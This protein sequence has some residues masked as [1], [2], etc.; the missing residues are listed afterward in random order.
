MGE[1]ARG[2]DQEQC[3]P[4]RKRLIVNGIVQGVGF[5]PSVYNLAVKHQLTGFVQNRSGEVIIEIEGLPQMI[6][7]FTQ[8]LY[9][10]NRPASIS[11]IEGIQLTV[12]ADET[13]SILPSETSAHA[14]LIFPPDLKS[15]QACTREVLVD[16][17]SRFY[18]YPFTSCTYCGP[19]YSA[20]RSLPYDRIH[21]TMDPFPMCPQCQRKY[22]SPDDRRF[23][24]QTIACPECGPS[25][26]ICE[27]DGVVVEDWFDFTINQLL[28]GK[29]IAMK[30]I[31][32]FHL[33]CDAMEEQA[34]GRLRQRKQRPRK[35]LALMAANIDT[36]NAFFHVSNEEE[37]ALTAPAAPILLLKPKPCASNKL[38]LHLIAPG[39]HRIGIMLPYTP[40]HAMLTQS[41]DFIVATSGN[42]SGHPIAHTNGEALSQLKGIADFFLLHDREIATRIDDSVGQVFDG[43]FVPIRRSRGIVPEAIA[44]PLPLNEFEWNQPIVF[45]AGAEMKNTFCFLFKGKALFSQHIGDIDNLEQMDAYEEAV[46]HLS[47][48]LDIK[49]D[50]IAYDPHPDYDI[51][52]RI[53]ETSNRR[54]A[55]VYHHHA[56]MTSCMAENM[57]EGPV[58]GCIL[59][60][61]GYG[62][63]GTMWGFEILT[64]DYLDFDRIHHLNPLTLPGGEHGIKN[65]WMVGI[66]LVYEASENERYFNETVKRLF[67]QHADKLPFIRAQLE[68]SIK[69]PKVS[70]AG[71][72]FDGISSI[73]GLCEE[74]AYEGEAAVLLSEVIEAVGIDHHF[75]HTS[76][77]SYPFVS[78]NGKWYISDMIR[79]LI[80]DLEVGIPK[81]EIILKFHHTI[82]EMVLDGVRNA[83]EKSGISEVV[84]SGGVWNNRYLLLYTKKR[85]QQSG[86]IVHTHQKIP[87]GDGG[88]A[89]GQAVSALWRWKLNHVSIH[90]S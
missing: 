84:L 7:E 54:V 40:L 1:L 26:S 66:S 44:F 12:Q 24:A 41:V 52:N 33:L 80:E 67:P 83:Y 58:I 89:L 76:I 23:H 73:L 30:G 77:N 87:C 60:G 72:I 5:R 3:L 2:K 21:T 10:I 9:T 71:R 36:I 61:T 35:P 19:R 13:F 37:E 27:H 64:G 85:L 25:V 14:P 22:D 53:I 59:D 57:L 45:G 6:T 34:I 79:T 82:G 75:P 39:L 88:I 47:E 43:K 31:G 90:T 8:D 81:S 50:I 55:P 42:K 69:S 38:P 20:I 17:T 63:D 28:K 46:Q 65:P 68:G 51:S 15:C 74:A 78:E 70:S 48:L 16:E 4:E 18:R 29:I 56:H 49:T 86:F 62:R 11:N 32:G